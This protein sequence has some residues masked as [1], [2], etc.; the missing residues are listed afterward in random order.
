MFAKRILLIPFLLL[1]FQL[2]LAEPQ[3]N[4]AKPNDN[5]LVQQVLDQL[6]QAASKAEG[7]LY[8]SLFHEKAVFIGTDPTETWDLQAFKKFAVPYFRKGTGWTY[9]PRD[10]HIYFSDSRQTAWFDEMLDNDKYGE[11]RGTGVLVKTNAGWKIT[12]YHLTIPV[13]NE[14]AIPLVKLIK[15]NLVKP[16][17]LN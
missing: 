14:L 5:L 10:R 1:F 12:Q 13:P 3:K 15:E 7:G 16:K 6:H 2:L 4:K 9:H 17:S 11:T 8:F